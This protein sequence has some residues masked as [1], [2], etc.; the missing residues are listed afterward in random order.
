[1][2]K[3][4]RGGEKKER[5]QCGCH[6]SQK[7]PGT[8]FKGPH[9]GNPKIHVSPA[10]YASIQIHVSIKICILREGGH[11]NSWDGTTPKFMGQRGEG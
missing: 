9:M 11:H 10:N 8:L 1:M 6:F 7:L 4:Y 5:D 3:G 2:G